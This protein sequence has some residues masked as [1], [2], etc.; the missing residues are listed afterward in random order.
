MQRSALPRFSVRSRILVVILI[1]TALGMSVSGIAASIVQRD[2]VIEGLDAELLATVEAARGIVTGTSTPTD[3]ETDTDSTIDAP[4]ASTAEALNDILSRIVP[5]RHESSVGIIDGQARLVPG[6]E[7]AF[8]LE[9]DPAFIERAWREASAGQVTVGTAITTVGTLRY[10]SVPV[11]IDG[12][13]ELGVYVIALDA[14]RAVDQVGGAF[15]TYAWLALVSLAAIGV[16]G[17][18]VAGRL[19][20]PLRRLSETASR[21]T[22]EDVSER[23]PVNGRDDVSALTETVNA[24]LDRIDEAL[25]SQRQ[26][27]DDVRH[28][29]KTPITIVRGHL[30]LLDASKPDDV[31]AVRDIAIDELDRMAE[32][33][34]D[35]D[36][37]ARVERQAIVTEPTDV[38]DL[39]ALVF[40]KMQAIP[41]RTWVLENSADVVAPLSPSRLTQAWLQ[42]ADNAAKYSPEGS[43]VRV[44][45]TAYARTVEF[46]VADEGPGIPAGAEKRIFER[47]GRAD[48]GRG[49]AGSGLGLPIV[50]A[51]ARAHGGYVSLDSSPA[52]ARFGIV[53][54]TLEVAAAPPPPAA[55]FDHAAAE[56][57]TSAP[58]PTASPSR[59]PE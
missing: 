16:I 4:P 10:V 20:A 52:G 24:M 13:P 53:V 42:L 23:I 37:L 55:G 8:A 25:T 15:L 40:S 3:S 22:A 59:R 35:I 31:I 56:A 12:D 30:E 19:L 44:G 46:W 47:F 9:D 51:I 49:I 50:A 54:P 32:L 18:F 39:T 14:Q 34:T 26:L 33:V 27:L 1:V 2:R 5:G 48:T 58:H 28:E 45:S 43:T 6:V 7:T 17:W 21:I 29:L 11:V 36:A 38:G 57:S 41:G